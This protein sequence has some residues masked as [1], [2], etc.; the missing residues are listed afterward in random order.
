[1][2][3]SIIENSEVARE[4]VL[5]RLRQRYERLR[6]LVR[7][8]DRD[9]VETRPLQGERGPVANGVPLRKLAVREHAGDA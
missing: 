7:T 4:A 1:M 6:Q 8:V 2:Q 3:E 5:T 9:A